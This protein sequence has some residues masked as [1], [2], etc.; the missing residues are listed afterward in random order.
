MNVVLDT[1]V[2]VSALLS[3]SGAPAAIIKLWENEAFNV[4]VSAEL[5]DELRHTLLY[6]K[7]KESL[8]W[9]DEAIG[10]FIDRYARIAILVTP[11]ARVEVVIQDPADNRVLECAIAG[12]ASFIITGD[13][14]LLEL[15]ETLGI[16]M[17]P[18]AG[19]LGLLALRP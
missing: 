5:I 12:G 13:K 19:F 1:N 15:K 17:L 14:H 11:Q 4:L 7:I 6:P 3:P 2:I 18:P 16:V 8:K 10:D 9:S